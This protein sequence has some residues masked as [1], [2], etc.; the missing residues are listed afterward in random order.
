[1][2]TDKKLPRREFL[3]IGSLAI[4][5]TAA[6]GLFRPERLFA[7][8]ADAAV[9][10]LLSVGYVPQAPDEEHPAARL[11]YAS[12]LLM[13]DT[14][15]LSRG[16]RVTLGSFERHS[17]TRSQA[18]AGVEIDA[19]YPANGYAPD[20]FPRFRAWMA[21]NKDGNE[22]GAPGARFTMPVTSTAGVQ[23][24]VGRPGSEANENAA[25]LLRLSTGVESGTLKLQRGLYVIAFRESGS[26]SA[27]NWG[28]YRLVWN[29]GALSIPNASFSYVI[30]TIDYAN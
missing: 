26:D 14:A 6:S 19:I 28:A 9:V 21:I 10:P 30:M 4:V 23:F 7:A 13:G 3:K 5:G 29:K 17:K 22:L 24:V 18:P 16:A 25:A 2:P 20:K 11:G 27:P 15:F 8:A 1:M 12:E